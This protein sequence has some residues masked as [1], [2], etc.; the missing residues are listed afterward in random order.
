MVSVA[1]MKDLERI[2][3]ECVKPKK[4]R[5]KATNWYFD[6]DDCVEM[7]NLQK[8][9]F[10]GRFYINLGVMVKNL[11]QTPEPKEYKCHV[12]IRLDRLVDDRDRIMRA[13][14]LE[15]ASMTGD[16][17]FAA[18]SE[19][20]NTHA[21]PFLSSMG[22]VDGIKKILTEKDFIKCWTMVVLKDYLFGSEWIS[23]NDT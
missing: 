3:N 23:G 11:D 22:T 18:V 6:T 20:I 2:I 5:K 17:R 14:N 12:R 19:A 4:F 8:D 21:L 15:D 16:E 7:I 13:L 9:D 10:G 1:N